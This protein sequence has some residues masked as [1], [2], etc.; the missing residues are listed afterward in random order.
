[1]VSDIRGSRELIGAAGGGRFAPDQPKQLQRHLETLLEDIH[2]RKRCG[3]YNQKKIQR[4]RV[5][6]V[7]AQMRRIYKSLQEKERER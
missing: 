3:Q 6:K 4:Y 7:N 5:Q 2:K 1:M